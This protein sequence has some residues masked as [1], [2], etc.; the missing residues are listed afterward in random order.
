[1]RTFYFA[2]N[3]IRHFSFNAEERFLP[4]YEFADIDNKNIV[5][6]DSF[7]ETFLVKCTLGQTISRYMVLAVPSLCGEGHCRH[8][9]PGLR[10]R[11]YLAHDW[12][13]Q[14]AHV[15]QGVNALEG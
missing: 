8:H 15:L 1:D 9:R 11:L 4:V 14:D 3:N 6:L 12:Q 10:K 13:R 2:N 5:H 7:A